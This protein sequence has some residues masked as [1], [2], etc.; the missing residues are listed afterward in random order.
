MSAI[1]VNSITGRTGS[2]GPVLTGVTTISG[3]LHVGSGLSVTGVS[4][5]SNTVVGGA[6]TELVV[7]GDARITGIL[8]IGTGSVTIDGTSGS[9]SIT[10]VSTAGIGSVY[11]VDSINDLG[12]PT[13]GPLSNRNLIINGAMQVAQRGTTVSTLN[14]AGYHTVDRFKFDIITFGVWTS[15]WM[16]NVQGQTY[17]AGATE[18]FRNAL[19]VTCTTPDLSP[20]GTDNVKIVYFVEGQDL[21]GVNYGQ[22]TAK[23]LTISFWVRSNK[24]GNATFEAIQEDNSDKQFSA[25]YTINAANTW[26]KK[27]IVIPAD[28][29]GVINNDNGRGLDLI[30]WLNSGATF[31]GGSQG[32]WRALVNANRNSDNIG[33]G[34][35]ANDEFYLTGVQLEVGSKSTPFEHRSYSDELQRCQ[36]YY[37]AVNGGFFRGFEITNGGGIKQSVTY[38]PVTMRAQPDVTV[39]G[40]DAASVAWNHPYGFGA[41]FTTPA[42]NGVAFNNYTADAE[43]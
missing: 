6:T 14:S 42:G 22:S 13:A 24:T 20:A 21:Q 10:G 17:E 11:G 41:N 32:G 39:S 30:W 9:S 1:N 27:V 4:T 31:T 29:S 18:R 12:F 25:S 7:G 34:S 3:D 26:E 28:T 33:V 35:A 2:H 15:D 43:L 40:G 37:N 36:R 16:T 19:R 8:T 38:F 5:F 23:D